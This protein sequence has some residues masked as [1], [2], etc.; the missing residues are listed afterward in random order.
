MPVT[1]GNDGNTLTLMST[2]S[3]T[4]SAISANQNATINANLALGAAQTWTVAGG[5][6]LTVGGP[7]SGT[8]PLTTAGAGTV[9]LM[10]NNTYSGSTAIS[11]GTLAV[12]GGA[13]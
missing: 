3:G 6:T 1:I 9:L 8:F 2:G 4:S 13:S 10:G 5:A 7:V 12:G 11:G